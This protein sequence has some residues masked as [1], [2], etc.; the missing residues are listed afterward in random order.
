[1]A[2]TTGKDVTSSSKGPESPKGGEGGNA[3]ANKDVVKTEEQAKAAESEKTRSPNIIDSGVKEEE[4]IDP[5]APNDT[6]IAFGGGMEVF[7]SSPL[8]KG[9]PVVVPL[10]DALR[11]Q[12]YAEK[13][14]VEG[15]ALAAPVLDGAPEMIMQGQQD[16]VPVPEKKPGQVVGV[17][18]VPGA[19]QVQ[20]DVVGKDGTVESQI[21]EA[22]RKTVKDFQESG[23]KD[24]KG[25]MQK[26]FEKTFSEKTR[27]QS[28]EE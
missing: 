1:M 18:D 23:N 3:S 2:T 27:V 7:T 11:S 4:R 26:F 5:G 24:P 16:S 15:V 8:L 6:K 21:H 28:T 9:I 22:D 19:N 25:G 20:V 17:H 14:L 12:G 13:D 10:S